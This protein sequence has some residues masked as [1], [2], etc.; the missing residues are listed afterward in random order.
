M[1]AHFIQLVID[2]ASKGMQCDKLHTETAL[3]LNAI[4]TSQRYSVRTSI[5]V[6]NKAASDEVASELGRR[7]VSASELGRRRG[8]KVEESL[9]AR[10]VAVVTGVERAGA[11][12]LQGMNMDGHLR[13]THT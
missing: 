6:A 7:R 10:V 3:H 2:V 1:D 9:V 8:S 13:H 12:Q 4:E 5:A 11:E